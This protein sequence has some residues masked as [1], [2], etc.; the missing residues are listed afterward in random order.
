MIAALATWLLAFH[1]LAL[2]HGAKPLP[3]NDFRVMRLEVQRLIRQIPGQNVVL[4]RYSPTHD[5]KREWVYNGADIDSSDVVWARD[6]SREQNAKLMEYFR[7]RNIWLL[8]PDLDTAAM[9][10]LRLL[11]RGNVIAGVGPRNPR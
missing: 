4:V 2:L 3:S 7:D 6:A 10:K 9:S 1:P 5:I 8:E 11:Q